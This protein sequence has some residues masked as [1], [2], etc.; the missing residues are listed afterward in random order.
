MCDNIIFFL[1]GGGGGGGVKQVQ[2]SLPASWSDWPS[3]WHGDPVDMIDVAVVS[4]D[5]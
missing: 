1:R 4:I 5:D 3:K 2:W